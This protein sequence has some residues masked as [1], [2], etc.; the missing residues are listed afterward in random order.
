MP[1]NLNNVPLFV[2]LPEA[3]PH[4]IAE[5]AVIR[6]RYACARCNRRYL[7]GTTGW[8]R[9][10]TGACGHAARGICIRLRCCSCCRGP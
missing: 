9:T 4:A 3:D 8:A 7:L 1:V 2:G 5:K 6:T 10:F